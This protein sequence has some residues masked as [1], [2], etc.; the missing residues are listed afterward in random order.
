MNESIGPLRVLLCA[1]ILRI[2]AHGIF[3]RPDSSKS[4]FVRFEACKSLLR[5]LP[6]IYIYYILYIYIYIYIY[7][8][9][10]YIYFHLLPSTSI[11]FPALQLLQSLRGRPDTFHSEHSACSTCI[12]SRDCL[13]LFNLYLRLRFYVILSRFDEFE[14]G[15]IYFL[16]KLSFKPVK[17]PRVLS[18]KP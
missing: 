15:F 18:S 17:R 2:E 5:L 1:A 10:I 16:L 4:T 11:Y 8:I 14:I 7:I 3:K 6:S 9:F 13:I 12:F